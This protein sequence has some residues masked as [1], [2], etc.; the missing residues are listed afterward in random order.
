[1]MYSAY[2]HWLNDFCFFLLFELCLSTNDKYYKTLYLSMLVLKVV[3]NHS[4]LTLQR[5]EIHL[6]VVIICLSE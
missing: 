6:V 4:L 2:L 5:L 1:M 3:I